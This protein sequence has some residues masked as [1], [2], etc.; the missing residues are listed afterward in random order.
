MSIPFV[1]FVV[2]L[3]LVVLF[4]KDM[5]A[6]VYFVVMTDI[7]LRL[8]TYLKT[9]I[10]KDTAFSFLD[11]IPSDVPE[12]IRSFDLDVLT[13]ILIFL[14]IVTYIIFEIFLIR[15]FVKKKF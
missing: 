2:A 12:I 11:A 3:I 4:Y 1:L 15:I 10:I 9:N 7:F 6:F 5:K 13:E 8:V 14:Y